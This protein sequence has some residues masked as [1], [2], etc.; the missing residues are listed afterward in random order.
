MILI[1]ILFG[2][3]CVGKST[4]MQRANKLN[5][6]VEMDNT[7]FWEYEEK[8]WSNICFNFL[9]KHIIKNKAKRNMVMTC[10]GLPDPSSPIYEHIEKKYNVVFRHSLVLTK[11]SDQ[12]FKQIKKRKRMDVLDT[13]MNHYK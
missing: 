5:Y 2:S 6:K 7:K 12:Y 8:L 4:L 13:L 9:I 11:S 1:N 3:S 10:G